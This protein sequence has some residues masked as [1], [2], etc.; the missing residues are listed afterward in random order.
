[1]GRKR[2]SGQHLPR[3][4]Y[5]RHGAYYFVDFSGNWIPLG[6]E[7]PKAMAKWAE[8]VDKPLVVRTM[9]DLF[10][11]YML[12]IAPNK[13]PLTY[14]GNQKEIQ[15][16]RAFFGEMRPDDVTPVH[17]Y[18]YLDIR[19]QKARVRANREKALLS[20]VFAMAIRWGEIGDN[21]CRN[22]KRLPEKP[23]NRYVEDAE[24]EAF[25]SGAPELIQ[26]WVAFKYLTGLRQG[27]ILALRLDQIK[28]DGIH[29]TIRKT[30]ERRVI[31]WS[32]ELKEVVA[33]IAA[34]PRPV[35][36]LYLFC[37]RKG[38]PYTSSGFRA[39]WQRAMRAALKSGRVKERFTEHDIR[40]KAAT[41]AEA[42]GMNAQKFLA[43]R[44]R[45]T[46]DGYIKSKRVERIL[47][48]SRKKT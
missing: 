40:G 27:D 9:N 29:V 16:L 17:I 42:A 21:P 28:E 32:D 14:L 5:H 24:L 8:L 22:V 25:V 31:D 6:K 44:H 7:L 2:K 39:I 33:D 3:R 4:V 1:M 10:D 13:A 30:G 23:R 47:P 15:P 43:H 48:L 11:R 18:K 12:E 19:G 20:H 41:D 35:R 36:G 45:N 26:L 34:M 37:N 38:Q 46:T